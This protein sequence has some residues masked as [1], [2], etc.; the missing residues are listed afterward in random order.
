MTLI[1]LVQCNIAVQNPLENEK[2]CY[3]YHEAPPIIELKAVIEKT[4][5]HKAS[6]E[7][8]IPAKMLKVTTGTTG[9][10]LW[11]HFIRIYNI[12]I[13]SIALQR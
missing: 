9:E 12:R 7:V 10:C 6:S 8:R 2:M 3:K 4:K 11:P 5:N 1:I 13:D